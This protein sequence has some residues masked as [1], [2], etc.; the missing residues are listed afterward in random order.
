[1]AYKRKTEDLYLLEYDYGYG[2]GLEEIYCASSL[3]EAKARKKDYI[4]NEGIW[5]VIRKKR[6]L[7]EEYRYER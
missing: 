1:M 3:R 5:P 4:E 2:D 6:V 7:K